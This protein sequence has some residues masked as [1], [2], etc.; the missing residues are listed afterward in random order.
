VQSFSKPK[1]FPYFGYYQ[2]NIGILPIPKF[3]RTNEAHL[4]ISQISHDAHKSHVADRLDELVMSLYDIGAEDLTH[5]RET[6]DMLTGNLHVAE[7]L[8]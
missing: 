8:T 3:D 6:L 5:L 1:G 7:A 2:W 4:Q